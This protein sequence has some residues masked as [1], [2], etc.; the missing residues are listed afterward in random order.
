MIVWFISHSSKNGT[1]RVRNILDNTNVKKVFVGSVVDNLK[2][3][4][5]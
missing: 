4:K 5:K 2:P 3:I 1:K